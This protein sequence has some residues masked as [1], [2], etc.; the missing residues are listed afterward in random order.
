MAD[1]VQKDQSASE[2]LICPIHHFP[3]APAHD[4]KTDEITMGCFLCDLEEAQNQ[5]GKA[6]GA[7]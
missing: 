3:Y 4:S 2:E 1:D 6:K 5:R 7:G